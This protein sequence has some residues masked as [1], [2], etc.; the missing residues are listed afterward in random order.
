MELHLNIFAGLCHVLY[1]R[2]YC[3]FLDV[4]L[5]RRHYNN[6][7]LI[8]GSIPD[9]KKRFVICAV[10]FCSE[11]IKL[12][13]ER[14][15]IQGYFPLIFVRTKI[16]ISVDSLIGNYAL[17]QLPSAFGR[18]FIFYKKGVEVLSHKKD[19]EKIL[20]LN[21]SFFIPGKT[22]KVIDDLVIFFGEEK[23]DWTGYS[24][25]FRNH[26]HVGSYLF[27]V[28]G[29]AFHQSVTSFF[30]KY[31]P[32]NT[33]F[34]NIHFGETRLTLELSSVC[35]PT[36]FL[37]QVY[38]EKLLHQYFENSSGNTHFMLGR[39]L[40]S[41]K[42]DF[43]Y[44]PIFDDDFSEYDFLLGAL[45]FFCEYGNVMTNLFLILVQIEQVPLLVKKDALFR[46]NSLAID[47]FINESSL[48]RQEI[49]ILLQKKRIYL[50]YSPFMR[51]FKFLDDH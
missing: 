24:F 17:F 33:R 16:P 39:F 13:I 30:N 2:I 42:L 31:L 18:D 10:P 9:G 37:N 47:E 22:F 23:N 28:S 36:V 27:Q 43:K 3:R 51:F 20:F 19:L 6:I 50:S 32:S 26:A 40:N 4:L 1:I 48:T 25:N 49:N 11:D 44:L 35:Q 29:K 41:Q 45:S 34:Y 8:K 7:R 46:Q 21:D 38:V 15:I 14:L 12:L 5:W